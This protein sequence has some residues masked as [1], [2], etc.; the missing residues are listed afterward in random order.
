M[1][2]IYPF[3]DQFFVELPDRW[4]GVHA[5]RRDEAIELAD[6]ANLPTSLKNFAV[7]MALLDDW[8]L[9]ALPK[10]PAKWVLDDVELRVIGWVTQ[11]VLP[12]FYENFI[13]PRN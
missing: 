12:A 4:L 6:K 13:V 7:A 11:A 8:H 2:I 1:K 3:D 10:N 9:P 5:R